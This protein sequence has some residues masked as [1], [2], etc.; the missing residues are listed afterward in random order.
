MR[1]YRLCKSGEKQVPIQD[2][3]GFFILGS[4]HAAGEKH[5]A[6]NKIYIRDE[7]EMIELLHLGY[8]VWVET[9]TSPSLVRRNLFVDGILIS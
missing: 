5:H 8:S 6:K 3:N 2:K 4:P 7:D 1:I 9:R